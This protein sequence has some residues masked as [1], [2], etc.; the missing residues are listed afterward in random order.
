M[1]SFTYSCLLYTVVACT[2]WI[3]TPSGIA[4]ESP[5]GQT[6]TIS[7]LIGLPGVTLEGLPGR[8]MTDRAGRY[9][10]QVPV[11]WS[12][13]VTPISVT[14]AERGF[15]FHPPSRTYDPVTTDLPNMDYRLVKAALPSLPPVLAEGLEVLLI[16]TSEQDIEQFQETREDIQ[17]M[18]HILREKLSEPRT[19]LGVLYDYGD[20]FGG[21]DNAQAFYLQGYGAL[22][23][24][25]MDFPFSE[26]V[27]DAAP[28]PVNSRNNGD[29]VWRRA[30][31]RMYAPRNMNRYGPLG[32]PGAPA[33]MSFEQLEEDLIA[34]LKHAA[35]IRNMDPNDRVVVTLIAR[36]QEPAPVSESPSSGSFSGGFGGWFQGSSFSTSGGSF[37]PGGGNTYSNSRAYASGSA[38][39]RQTPQRAPRRPPTGTARPAAPA[40]VLTIQASK[41]DIDTFA[42]GTIDLTQFRQRVK[43]ITY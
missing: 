29:P 16:P 39:A 23:V 9:S 21:Q 35:N 15:E 8:P 32:A 43:T 41:A 22:F 18:L 2:L 38:Q 14:A 12:G 13:V 42:Q 25:K 20:F 36:D 27:P 24:L 11:G 17:I 33:P 37:G 10:V 30:R 40:T 1:K 6:V 28:G 19:I 7:G 4:A 26:A 34:T 5:T 31:Q 3:G